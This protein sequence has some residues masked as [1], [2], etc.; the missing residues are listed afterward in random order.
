MVGGWPK[1]QGNPATFLYSSIFP[2][3]AGRADKGREALHASEKWYSIQ[4]N[5]PLSQVKHRKFSC[6]EALQFSGNLHPR[7]AYSHHRGIYFF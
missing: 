2:I 6:T 4:R 7:S 1:R 3:G 5:R